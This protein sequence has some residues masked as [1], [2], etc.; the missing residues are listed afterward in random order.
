MTLDE[1]LEAYEKRKLKE[2]PIAVPGDWSGFGENFEM[3]ISLDYFDTLWKKV[4]VININDQQFIVAKLLSGDVYIAGF[5]TTI[6]RDT[7]SGPETK[8]IFKTVF[9]ITFDD[10]SSVGNKLGYKNLYSVNGVYVSEKFRNQGLA[11]KM[12]KWF[13]NNLE[14]NILGDKHQYFGARKLWTYLSN[15][16]DIQVDLVDLNN[17]EILETDVILY[18][19]KQDGEYDQSVWSDDNS[20]ANIRPI[21][22]KIM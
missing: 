13:V 6:L 12:Y 10:R 16:I 4:D 17:S 22:T 2:Q 15:Q 11:A 7:K 9:Q 20:K 5:E 3:D 8:N 14:L 21:L 19:G 18:H 1:L